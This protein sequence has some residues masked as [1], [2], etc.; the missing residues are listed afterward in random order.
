MHPSISIFYFRG[1]VMRIP[2]LSLFLLVLV[3]RAAVLTPVAAIALATSRLNGGTG[4]Q[5]KDEAAAVAV[6]ESGVKRGLSR[7]S[8]EHL[9]LE[10]APEDAVFRRGETVV[11]LSPLELPDGSLPSSPD[12]LSFNAPGALLRVVEGSA[13]AEEASAKTAA[14]DESKSAAIKEEKIFVTV[15]PLFAAV[16]KAADG[17]TRVELV[18]APPSPSPSNGSSRGS[19]DS[20]RITL[21]MA[22]AKSALRVVAGA[23]PTETPTDDLSA[24]SGSERPTDLSVYVRGQA[25]LG[26]F[27]LR[28][29]M[30]PTGDVEATSRLWLDQD[31]YAD[32]A[33][34]GGEV[35]N[36]VLASQGLLLPNATEEQHTGAAH[37]GKGATG[38]MNVEGDDQKQNRA[39]A[40]GEVELPIKKSAPA[41]LAMAHLQKHVLLLQDPKNALRCVLLRDGLASSSGD[42]DH[43]NNSGKVVET[44]EKNHVRQMNVRQRVTGEPSKAVLGAAL[45]R[46]LPR[47]LLS[48][49]SKVTK[50]GSVVRNA[51]GRFKTALASG[52]SALFRIRAIGR[53][54]RNA[55]EK[56]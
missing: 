32:M 52:R 6:A 25:D 40:V 53:R 16:T 42:E 37:E 51:A 39:E 18:P 54:S 44:R 20:A 1:R 50:F 17:T 23:A 13:T 8:A 47:M 11:L 45:N 12:A 33:A 10:D 36:K 30:Q 49:G 21:P 19:E 3:D 27:A 15:E 56:C 29:E 24:S 41:P 9:S 26:V 7:F 48:L 4:G 55:A 5:E 28:P 46:R 31:F 43:D 14:S 35:D 22:T 38:N 34:A 2:W